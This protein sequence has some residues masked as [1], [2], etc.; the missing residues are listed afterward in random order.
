MK[1]LPQPTSS[2]SAH[3]GST[4]ATSSAMSYA[5]PTLRRRRMRRKRRLIVVSNVVTPALL[6]RQC[7]NVLSENSRE[8]SCRVQRMA[9]TC[10]RMAECIHD[11]NGCRIDHDV[12]DTCR[13]LAARKEPATHREDPNDSARAG[14]DQT[15]TRRAPGS[16]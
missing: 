15:L 10:W 11:K 14:H 5:R 2:T 1:P 6:Q 4:R 7:L 3:G 8:S 16:R 13:L 9:D 12:A